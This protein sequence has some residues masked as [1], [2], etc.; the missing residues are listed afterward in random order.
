MISMAEHE[1][2]L[3]GDLEDSGR[4]TLGRGQVISKTEMMDNPGDYP[5][6]SSSATNNGEIGRYSQ[7]MF[8]DEKITWSI[9]GGGKFFYRAPHKYSVTNVCGWLKVNDTGIL[10]RYLYHAL[11]NE[12]DKKVYDYLHK[13]H[14]S[15]I[16]KE[17]SISIP[18][19]AIQKQFIAFV[20]QSDKSKLFGA[21]HRIQHITG[22]YTCLVKQI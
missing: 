14:P 19:V 18:D 20:E 21:M 2:F 16:R 13:A 6:Y 8:D 15:V 7:Y 11:M 5:V 22:G 3:L 10:T 12:W 17:Y 4:I 1:E 9:D